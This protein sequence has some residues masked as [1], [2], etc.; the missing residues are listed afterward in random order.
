MMQSHRR[1]PPNGFDE[2]LEALNG[3]GEAATPK[4]PKPPPLLAPPENGLGFDCPK[5]PPPN[6]VVPLPNPEA[7]P[8]P[9]DISCENGHDLPF[10]QLPLAKNLHG[11]FFPPPPN[12][13][14]GCPE[15]TPNGDTLLPPPL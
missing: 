11:G 2:P 12:V 14:V 4:L 1:G 8:P 3:D 5:P 7:T 15:D 13:L 10:R 6:D 9:P